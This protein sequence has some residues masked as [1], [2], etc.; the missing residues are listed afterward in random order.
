VAGAVEVLRQRDLASVDVSDEA[1]GR[2]VDDLERAL[3]TT[4]WR[5]CATYFH[6]PQGDIV[7]QMPHTAGWYAEAV[8]NFDPADYELTA[9]PSSV[10]R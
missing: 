5:G 6:S 10:P 4:V 7:T 8:R 1:M 3:A 9:L 2:Y